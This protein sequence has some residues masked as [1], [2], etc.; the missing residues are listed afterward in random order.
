MVEWVYNGEQVKTHLDPND[1]DQDGVVRKAS[2]NE[3]EILDFGGENVP[4]YCVVSTN[5]HYKLTNIV[6]TING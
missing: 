6:L 4:P 2:D 5:T 3:N 1:E